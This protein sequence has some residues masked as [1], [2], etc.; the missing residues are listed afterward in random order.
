NLPGDTTFHAFLWQNGVMTDLG[1]LPGHSSSAAFGINGKGQIVGQSCSDVECRAFL[2]EGGVMTDLNDLIPPD[3]SM[4]LF[5]PVSINTRGLLE[6][7]AMDINPLE[8]R[9]FLATPSNGNIGGSVVTS[10]AP[11]KIHLPETSRTL[12]K[13]GVA[14][15]AYVRATPS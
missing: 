1:T 15:K 13:H 7:A 4:F 8:T 3:S 2:W 10:A 6:C 5:E 9:P 11:S 12:L 14:R